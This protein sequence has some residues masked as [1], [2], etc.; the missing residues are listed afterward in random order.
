MRTALP[1]LIRLD[2][3]SKSFGTIRA[4]RNIS[5]DIHAGR[6]KALLGE[7]GAGKSTLMSV[8][9]GRLRPDTGHI[10]IDG[11]VQSDYSTQA[12]IRAGIGMVYQHFMLIEAMTV[13]ENI[14][15]GQD[16]GFFLHPREMNARVSALAD[17]FGLRIDPDVTIS[18]LSMGERQRVEILKL[19]FRESR[20]LIFDEPTAVLTPQETEQLF[21]A[22]RQMAQQG[23]AIVFISHKLTEVMALADEIAIL[24]KGV[25]VDQLDA[26]SVTSGAELARRMVGR[27]V[28]LQVDRE[29]LEP[30]QIV[31]RIEGLSDAVLFD[32]GLT[33][34]QG[35]IF[36][37]LGVAGNGQKRLVEIICGLHPPAVGKIRILGQPWA[38]FF[39]TRKW[40]AALSYIPED[41][42]GLATCLGLDLVDNFLLTTREGF[43]SP[44]P[45]P[46]PAPPPGLHCR[47]LRSNDRFWLK[48]EIGKNGGF[49]P[50][51]LRRF[52]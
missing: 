41:R 23:K 48:A 35:E 11:A 24:R 12:A 1:P 50:P 19:L 49:P 36:G 26:G 47:A 46:A 31:L 25:V 34:R 16:S 39:S 43:T 14:F 30:K 15:L 22:I 33:V 18:Q 40:D 9:S 7:N 17:T 51:R 28:L 42:R 29:P 32:L 38:S 2:N 52:R 45:P 3:I 37:I 10:L 6:I 13:A 5:L 8:L 21:D 27:D 4:N 20:V 44:F